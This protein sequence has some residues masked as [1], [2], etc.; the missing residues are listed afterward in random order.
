MKDFVFQT[1]KDQNY[2]LKKE[3]EIITG[4]IIM[5]SQNIK[6]K[7]PNSLQRRKNVHT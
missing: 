1:E 2:R 3:E 7:D 6:D 5:N 4:H